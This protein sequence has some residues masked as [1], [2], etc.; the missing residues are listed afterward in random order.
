M[1]E[2][3]SVVFCRYSLKIYIILLSLSR[4]VNSY[5]NIALAFPS[6]RKQYSYKLTEEVA[7]AGMHAN[8]SWLIL[9]KPLNLSRQNF[10]QPKYQFFWLQSL[11]PILEKR[12]W[13]SRHQESLRF[14]FVRLHSLL[15]CSCVFELP[16]SIF[17]NRTIRVALG[18][19]ELLLIT[20]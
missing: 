10:P 12:L 1:F 8:V 15:Y 2:V 17:F 5:L 20:F 18:T 13:H 4:T 19:Y 11:I 7:S 14:S 6:L 3:C 9:K 16:F